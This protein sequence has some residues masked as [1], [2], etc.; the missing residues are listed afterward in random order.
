MIGPIRNLG[1]SRLCT[2]VCSYVSVCRKDRRRCQGGETRNKKKD[3]I[4]PTAPLAGG[5]FRPSS[6]RYGKFRRGSIEV[7]SFP[8]LSL[9][10][11]GV[12]VGRLGVE[13]GERDTSPDEYSAGKR[14][15]EAYGRRGGGGDDERMTKNMASS[16]GGR[17]E[18]TTMFA[19]PSGLFFFASFWDIGD[20][21]RK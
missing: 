3:P 20:L 16:S 8:S 1:Q 10:G 21:L 7:T 19:S 2:Y 14:E 9:C 15:N 13:A 4:R 17:P 12:N 6:N 5:L 18:E 11:G